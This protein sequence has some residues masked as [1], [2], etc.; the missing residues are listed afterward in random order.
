MAH[1]DATVDIPNNVITHGDVIIGHGTKQSLHCVIPRQ[2][3]VKES[4]P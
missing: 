4:P 2:N 1:Y 3:S